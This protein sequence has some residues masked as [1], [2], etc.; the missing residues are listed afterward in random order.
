MLKILTS[1]QFFLGFWMS[2]LITSIINI[3]LGS[4]FAIITTIVDAIMVY[5]YV[6]REM[7]NAD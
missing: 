6:H 2:L 5:Y 7:N 1:N 4:K 3:M